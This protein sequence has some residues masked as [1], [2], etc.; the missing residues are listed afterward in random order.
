M[1]SLA[2]RPVDGALEADRATA[3]AGAGAEV[4][5]V[6]GDRD[7]L[8]LVLD[9]E[10]GVALVAQ[11]EQ[12]LVHPLDV[13]GVQPD[14]RLVEDVGDV[15]ERGPEVPDHL[16]ALGLAA[17]QRAGRPVEGEVAQPDL[18]EGV[19]QVL[20]ALEQ[21]RH[22]RLVELAHPVGEVADLHRAQ[23]G[24]APAADQGG[25][26]LGGEAGAV[27][28]GAGLEGDGAARRSGAR[29]AASPRGPWTSIDFWI[30]GMMPSKVR[31]TPSTLIFVGGAKSIVSSCLSVND[32]M[33][34]SIGR[35]MP[36]NSR[37]YHPS[38]E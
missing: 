26:R 19:E 20:Q 32:A 33:G 22:R 11:L 4:D 37:P 28:L 16:G 18:G 7:G 29:A 34:L 21:R 17:G 31:L 10:H 9:H 13:V 14:R 24:D 3:G 5:D 15:G 30:L 12:Q 27:A 23:V 25:P 38:I 36:S 6:V 35:P 2:R 8:R 1:V